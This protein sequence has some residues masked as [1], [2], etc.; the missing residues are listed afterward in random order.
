M[1]RRVEAIEGHLQQQSATRTPSKALPQ[2]LQATWV[3]EQAIL[4]RVELLEGRQ[5]DSEQ[6][7]QRRLE[8][9][10]GRSQGDKHGAASFFL[11]RNPAPVPQ[12]LVNERVE[13][14]LL[15]VS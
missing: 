3:N 6:V 12:N 2:A 10:E 7:L 5:Q 8:A 4:R 9:L 13:E 14:R 11:S 1:L 15:E